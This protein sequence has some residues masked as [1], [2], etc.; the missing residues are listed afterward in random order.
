MRTR[1]KLTRGDVV[2]IVLAVLGTLAGIVAVVLK[3]VS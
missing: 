3:I 2:E 1:E